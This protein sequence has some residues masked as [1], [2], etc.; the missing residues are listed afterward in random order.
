MQ[1]CSTNRNY[2]LL[3]GTISHDVL[4][5]PTSSLLSSTKTRHSLSWLAPV[6]YG[7]RP[8]TAAGIHGEK[9]DIGCIWKSF[10]GRAA[11]TKSLVAQDPLGYRSSVHDGKDGSLKNLTRIWDLTNENSGKG[12]D[13]GFG[14]L[15][16]G[17]LRRKTGTSSTLEV[18]SLD[19]GTE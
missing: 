17:L 5:P 16:T 19:G 13:Q 6:S 1:G 10:S 11:S 18:L 4:S 7:R 12:R 9:S 3:V 2:A 8:I 15:D 14:E